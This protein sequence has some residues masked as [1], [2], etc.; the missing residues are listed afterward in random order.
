VAGI[1]TRLDFEARGPLRGLNRVRILRASVKI[2]E[3]RAARAEAKVSASAAAPEPAGPP[4]LPARLAA[5]AALA[6]AIARRN[7]H[8]HI[9]SVFK[10]HMSVG[11]F[12]VPPYL[13]KRTQSVLRRQA[14]IK[15]LCADLFTRRHNNSH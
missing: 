7:P 11:G 13:S 9:P 10:P 5:E 1:P 6:E 3:E 2:E 15:G 4:K 14:E 12:W 8:P